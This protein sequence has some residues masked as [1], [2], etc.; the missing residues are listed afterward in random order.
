MFRT[1][2]VL[3]VLVIGV[4]ASLSIEGTHAAPARAATATLRLVAERDHVEGAVLTAEAI[5]ADATRIYL[6]TA[7][8]NTTNPPHQGR[9][10]VLARDEDAGFPLIQTINTP[11][12]L[13]AVDG[14]RKR[15][16]VTSTDGL[17]RVYRK[18]T[19]LTLVKSV[20]L[21]TPPLPLGALEVRSKVLYVSVGP[22]MVARG[23]SLYLSSLNSTDVVLEVPKRTLEAGR[24]FGQPFEAQT[25]VVYDRK[26][27]DRLGGLANPLDIR[28][29]PSQVEL[30]VDHKYLARTIAGCCGFGVLLNNAKTLAQGPTVE[31]RS[32]TNVIER[33]GRWLIGGSEGGQVDVYD[34]RKAPAPLVSSLDLRTLTGHTGVEDIEIRALWTDHFDNLIFAGSSWGNDQSRGPDLPA[35]FVLELTTN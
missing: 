25:T 15:L 16:Y 35:F 5:Y 4:A 6:A 12:P 20:A 19:P 14:D 32:S 30:Y 11:S 27:G 2:A 24:S 9:L 33:R 13:F 28:G 29:Q 22:A 7:T 3:A 10:L 17:L 23:R 1:S 26:T 21:T 18:T 31:A 34:L 8:A